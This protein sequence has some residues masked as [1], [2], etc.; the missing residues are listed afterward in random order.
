MAL[1]VSEG[2]ELFDLLARA[3]D[4]EPAATRTDLLARL[5]LLLAH[6]VG[7]M[8]QV[9]DAVREARLIAQTTEEDPS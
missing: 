9:R 3:Y 2:D 4:G 8:D 1:G 7:D 6:R 5:C